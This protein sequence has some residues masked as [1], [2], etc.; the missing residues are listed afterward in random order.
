MRLA[1]GRTDAHE[2]PLCEM[3][4]IRSGVTNKFLLAVSPLHTWEGFVAPWQ[5]DSAKAQA[6]FSVARSEVAKIV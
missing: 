1:L 2:L 6:A 4:M 5:G 3:I